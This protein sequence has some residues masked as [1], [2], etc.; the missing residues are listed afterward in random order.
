LHSCRCIVFGCLDSN[1]VLNSNCLFV[2]KG[3]R[4]RKKEKTTSANPSCSSPAPPLQPTFLFSRARSAQS[5]SLLV[6]LSFS[7]PL[8]SFRRCGPASRLPFPARCGPC[9]R[10]GRPLSL[11]GGGHPSSPTSGR[12]RLGLVPE[13]ARRAPGGLGP[14]RQATPLP[15]LFKAA[16]RSAALPYPAPA[17]LAARACAAATS[18]PSRA[19][20]R[21]KLS[22]PPPFR[23]REVYREHCKEVRDSSVF[24]VCVRVHRV[25]GSASPDLRRRISSPSAVP[26]PS[27]PPRKPTVTFTG[28][29]SSSW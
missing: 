26:A 16:S 17:T 12:F 2:L 10:R 8:S 6:P 22:C 20:R 18:N 3:N 5:R 11:T 19:V 15:G 9:S 25:A 21:R 7:P 13:S 27:S 29:S 28:R 1:L 24:F 23:R 4:I 14:P